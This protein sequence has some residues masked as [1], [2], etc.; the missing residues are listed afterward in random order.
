[1]SKYSDLKIITVTVILTIIFVLLPPINTTPV[2]TILGIPL[3]LFLPGYALIAM[4][5]PKKSD[6]DGIERLALSFGL[7]IAIVPLIGL[8]L[9]FTP[10]GIRLVP[11][12]LCI[13]FFTLVMCA[14]A[15]LRRSKLSE[16][17]RFEVTFSNI[18]PLIK[19]NLN[20]KTR[21]D[22][23]LTV[24]LILSIIISVIMLIYVMITPKQ[25]EKFTEFYI[26][27]DNGK[28]EGYPKDLEIGKNASVILGIVNHEYVT[29]N[30]T[31]KISLDNDTL[32]EI[33]IPLMHNT[34]W[35]KKVLFTPS[36]TGNYIKLG[37]FLYKENNFSMPYRDLHL[38]VNVSS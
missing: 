13:S 14:V 5:F 8:V 35:E 18:F 12:L 36:K 24:I 31:L 17:E 2:R 34:T 38:W 32:S 19:E 25:G 7:S 23:V 20:S 1:V 4:L 22:K 26:L 33:D 15:Y 29:M 28:A 21:L 16:S 3:V 6:L 27:G 37:F 10:F 11:V 9:N 30:Y